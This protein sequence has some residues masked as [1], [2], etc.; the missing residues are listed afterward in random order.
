MLAQVQRK[1][2]EHPRAVVERHRP[3]RR[4]A[5]TTRMVQHLGR[6]ERSARAAEDPPPSP[7]PRSRARHRL[8]GS[9]GR[10]RSCGPDTWNG[11]PRASLTVLRG[12]CKP[13]ARGGSTMDDTE[14]ARRAA[15]AMWSG[16]AASRW[17]GMA[18]E[19]VG[20]GRATMTLTVAPHHCNGHG[21]C[22]GGVIFALA[23]SAFAFACNSATTRRTVAAARA[24]VSFTCTPY[25]W[26]TSCEARGDGSVIATGH[27]TAS[28]T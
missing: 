23:D 22:H 1:R 19:E 9:S 7:R 12:P 25:A 10:P 20:P 21:T 28:T 18:L 15:E 13:R 4:A 27:A 24:T 8:A 26:E 5:D 2:L 3:E 14:R 11:P 17:F 6:I 16:D